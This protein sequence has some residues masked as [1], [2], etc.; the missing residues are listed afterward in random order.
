MKI[1][2]FLFSLVAMSKSISD[3]DMELIRKKLK[4]KNSKI[5]KIYKPAPKVG[6]DFELKGYDIER[7]SDLILEETLSKN[8]I[9]NVSF[10]R[11]SPVQFNLDKNFKDKMQQA[12]VDNTSDFEAKPFLNKKA[13]YV[14]FKE[15]PSKNQVFETTLRLVMES[16][17][18]TYF[19][20]L[21]A[22]KC[23]SKGAS[24][25]PIAYNLKKQGSK[26]LT[27]EDENLM[28]PED[29]ILMLSE[30]LPR[31]NGFNKI[32]F[33]DMKTSSNSDVY[34]FSLE[35]QYRDYPKT[36]K[37]DDKSVQPRPRQPMIHV[38]DNF[39]MN[40]KKNKLRYLPSVTKAI[41][42]FKEKREELAENN[43][44]GLERYSFYVNIDKKW[45][46]KSRY[47]YVMLKFPDTK[48]YE[49]YM[50]DLY[51]YFKKLKDRELKV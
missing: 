33:R 31:K 2:I 3:K 48:H 37:L 16:N 5:K 23:P 27:F 30:G 32:S 26:S 25:Y 38:L 49:Y 42:N 7:D 17:D 39:Q 6:N 50:I 51:E 44:K 21:F 22:E 29:K 41:L 8:D 11:N 36:L 13:V 10:C 9:L 15:S 40:L 19:I 28:T 45:M 35:I 12:I 47:I 24:P 4:E 34:V 18:V 14:K 20:K 46:R 43:M 1:F